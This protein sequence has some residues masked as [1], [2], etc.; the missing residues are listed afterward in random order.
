M[1]ALVRYAGSR[2]KQAPTPPREPP[3]H[4]LAS[5]PMFGTVASVL[6]CAKCGFQPSPHI[7]PLIDISIPISMTPMHTAGLLTPVA[8]EDCLADWTRRE[9]VE[10]ASCELCSMSSK[11]DQLHHHKDV[12]SQ[13]LGGIGRTRSGMVT[14]I[15]DEETQ[16]IQGLEDLRTNARFGDIQGAPRTHGMYK[17]LY[18]LRPPDVLTVHLRRLVGGMRKLHARVVFPLVLDLRKL[19][20]SFAHLGSSTKRRQCSVASCASHTGDDVV[21][22]VNCRRCPRMGG[23]CVQHFGEH[24]QAHKR[25]DSDSASASASS[26]EPG[27]TEPC[28]TPA[29]MYVLKAV[30][31]HVGDATGGHYIVYREGL[32]GGG[33]VMV[34]DDSVHSVSE[35][36]VLAAQAYL[37]FY[38]KLQGAKKE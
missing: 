37:L 33:W 1:P 10:G 3:S 28:P 24:L 21:R 8:L 35:E 27:G 23:L 32:G 15:D 6:T 22:L 14:Q 31:E 36:R 13:L 34:S 26:P 18:L 2:G 20:S 38:Q 4:A 17:Q 5:H 19:T 11:L 25:E 12:A 30:V 16:L 9:Y 7:E 29:S